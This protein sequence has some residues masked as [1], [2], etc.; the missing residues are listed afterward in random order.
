[1]NLS[2]LKK[3]AMEGWKSL[4]DFRRERVNPSPEEILR[5]LDETLGRPP[6]GGG[7][8]PPPTIEGGVDL[9]GLCLPPE[10]KGERSI[11]TMK[12]NNTNR[13]Q[14]ELSDTYSK[15]ID[16]LI[17][18]CDLRTKKDVIENALTLLGWAALEASK[19][20]TIAAVD[21]QDK[22]Y[23][24][25]TTTALEGAGTYHERMGEVGDG[26]TDPSSPPQTKAQQVVVGAG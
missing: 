20:R 24:E 22:F 18:M 14:L 26:S 12:H 13:L 7:P 23:R 21:E 3:A 9:S 4:R 17:P 2:Q 8:K 16:R 6:N 10:K 19:G 15:M 1:M 11:M 25:F 5:E